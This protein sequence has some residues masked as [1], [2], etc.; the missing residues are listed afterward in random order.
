MVR[1]WSYPQNCFSNV[2]FHFF[3]LSQKIDLLK[4]NLV[5]NY[6]IVPYILEF[7]GE[8]WR[9][10]ARGQGCRPFVQIKRSDRELI[11]NVMLKKFRYQWHCIQKQFYYHNENPANVRKRCTRKKHYLAMFASLGH[12]AT[13]DFCVVGQTLLLLPLGLH[14]RIL[15]FRKVR[16]NQTMLAMQS[17]K[18]T[19]N[20]WGWELYMEVYVFNIGGTGRRKLKCSGQDQRLGKE[21]DGIILKQVYNW[22]NRSGSVWVQ[23]E[24]RQGKWRV[25]SMF[26]L[27]AAVVKVCARGLTEKYHKATRY[28]CYMTH[29]YP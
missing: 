9:A 23:G 24:E 4:W 15:S 17:T 27:K 11:R 2:H 19:E 21:K 14:A 12:F 13:A 29:S 26:G 18:R 16:K 22:S 20:V 25:V 1:D 6:V 8:G 3:W 28:I 5:W 7:P 10:T